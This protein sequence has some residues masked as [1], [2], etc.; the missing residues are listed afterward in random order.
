V[1]QDPDGRQVEDAHSLHQWLLERSPN[2]L[3]DTYVNGNAPELDAN[4]T[5][6]DVFRTTVAQPEPVN[7]LLEQMDQWG[8]RKALLSAPQGPGRD[9]EKDHRWA[10]EVVQ[11]HPDRFALA[12]RIDPSMGMRGV[13]LLE[14]MV[15]NDGLTALRFTPV[16]IGKPINNKIYYPLFTKCAELNI[17]ITV[18]TGIA[19]PRLPSMIQHPKHFDDL[20]HFFPEL[21]IVSTHGG[22]PWQALLVKLMAKWPNLFHMVSAFAPRYYPTETMDFL[23]SSRGREKVMF[24]S[25]YPLINW[26]RIMPELTLLNLPDAS[27][28]AFLYG[29]AQ[30]VFWDRTAMTSARQI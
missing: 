17:P 25:D 2:G 16:F 11:Q 12:G 22:E 24:A 29:N 30:R 23:R 6:S 1:Q 10:A 18:L 27:W 21:T 15:R 14:S 19:G 7:S 28:A 8:I 20:C 3:I 9:P 13:R 4:W 5:K 26:G